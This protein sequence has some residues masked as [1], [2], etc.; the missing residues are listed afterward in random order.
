MVVNKAY[1][2]DGAEDDPRAAALGPASARVQACRLAVL[3]VMMLMKVPGVR[4]S[5][6]FLGAVFFRLPATVATLYG[7]RLSVDA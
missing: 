7:G 5:D 1:E 6:R 2:A 4:Q 3:S